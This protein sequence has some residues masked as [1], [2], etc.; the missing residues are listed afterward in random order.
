MYVCSLDHLRHTFELEHDC[1]IENSFD[2]AIDVVSRGKKR[3]KFVKAVRGA[4]LDDMSD[5][6]TRRTE[7]DNVKSE[8]ESSALRESVTQYVNQNFRG[9]K[10]EEWEAIADD[11]GYANSKIDEHGQGMMGMH[12]LFNT[13]QSR[14]QHAHIDGIGH[15]VNLEQLPDK[16]E[17][18]EGPLSV[19]VLVSK[20]R[21][22]QFGEMY[23]I[24][25]GFYDVVSGCR[26]PAEF[27]EEVTGVLQRNQQRFKQ[28]LPH[29]KPV[30]KVT[31][32]IFPKNMCVHCGVPRGNPDQGDRKVLYFTLC[33]KNKVHEY[34]ADKME[35]AEYSPGFED[36]T[37]N[38]ES[39]I[40][41]ITQYLISVEVI[42]QTSAMI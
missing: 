37:F 39:L 5:G 10:L 19:A 8:R 25:N 24:A 17:D 41:W 36:G 2:V 23:P 32:S 21:N 18:Y 6:V 4:T 9:K 7:V 13:S 27:C 38:K 30:T 15:K 11:P 12:A 40:L 16:L 34:K 29:A 22:T 35:T 42:Q 26:D 28:E 3:R 14:G 1:V 33:R 31:V 20:H